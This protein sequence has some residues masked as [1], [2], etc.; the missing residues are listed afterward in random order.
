MWRTA[1]ARPRSCS[2]Y[3]RKTE[4]APPETAAPARSIR[5]TVCRGINL[6]FSVPLFR[7]YRHGRRRGCRPEERVVNFDF[8]LRAQIVHRLLGDIGTQLLFNVGLHIGQLL[9]L[10]GRDQNDVVSER[11][12]DRFADFPHL[13]SEGSL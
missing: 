2:A 9:R 13:Q 10:M 5:W 12:F 11:A 8:V 1:A 6:C 7:L 4:S 3:S